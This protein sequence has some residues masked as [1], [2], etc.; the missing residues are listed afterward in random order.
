MHTPHPPTKKKR[1]HSLYGW[2][3]ILKRTKKTSN[4]NTWYKPWGPSRIHAVGILPLRPCAW[5][6][7]MMTCVSKRTYIGHF[8]SYYFLHIGGGFLLNISNMMSAL[9]LYLTTFIRDNQKIRASFHDI[10]QVEA[11]LGEFV[12]MYAHTATRGRVVS[13]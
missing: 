10:R 1:G 11:Q 6:M 2:I 9:L 5:A 3:H 13:Q 8:S 4:N 7:M 12:I